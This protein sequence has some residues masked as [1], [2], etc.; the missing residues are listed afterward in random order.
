MAREPK[1]R[2]MQD[3]LGLHV[4]YLITGLA[5]AFLFGRLAADRLG[6]WLVPQTSESLS[7]AFAQFRPLLIEFFGLPI[8]VLSIVAVCLKRRRWRE[9]LPLWILAAGTG[10]GWFADWEAE[11]AP[12]ADFAYLSLLFY[13]LSATWTGCRGGVARLASFVVRRSS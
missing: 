10:A 1:A 7:F 6:V 9:F 4:F 13:G 8:A 2:D 12:L 3:R 11:S 5:A